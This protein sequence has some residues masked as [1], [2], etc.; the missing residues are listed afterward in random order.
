[1]KKNAAISDPEEISPTDPAEGSPVDMIFVK[2]HIHEDP[3]S[4][5]L[6]YLSRKFEDPAE[7]ECY[8]ASILQIECRQ[9]YDR[10]F[11]GLLSTFPDFI[12]PA[13]LAGEQASHL[14]IS[15]LHAITASRYYDRD[16]DVCHR[17]VDLTAGLGIDFMSIASSLSSSGERCTAIELDKGKASALRVNLEAA[18]LPN[19]SI[20]NC[21]SMKWVKDLPSGKAGIIFADPARRGDDDG[22]IY[23]PRECLPDIVG[24]W[25]ELLDKAHLLIIKNSPMLD[26]DMA[27]KTFPGAIRI[28]VA[29]VK[30]ECKEILVVARK[31]GSLEGI[32]CINI[33]GGNRNVISGQQISSLAHG[34]D[35]W[36]DMELRSESISIP[37]CMSDSSIREIPLADESDLAAIE[38]DDALSLYEPNSSVM[39]V[40]PWRFIVN[41]FAGMKKL[42][43]NCHLFVSDHYHADFPGRRMRLMRRLDKEG[44][45]GLKGGRLNIVT[46]NYPCSPEKLSC[47]LRI[48]SGGKDFL[49]GATI[50]S[51][52]SPL[53]LL[54]SPCQQG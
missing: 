43:P 23:D 9:R 18:G 26:V 42:S 34:A 19:A 49:Y 47:E 10:K 12:F 6:K 33:L 37:A 54:A 13:R 30:N 36:N 38:G 25:Q 40:M 2:K 3:S 28:I 31:G 51:A 14:W 45:K 21:D 52:D 48:K 39:K 7:R 41:R 32:D 29:S 22:R 16:I 53:L 17:L 27:V 20:L 46:R 15:R 8:E 4:L 24:I 44:R 35:L 5:R 50:G 1:M 11:P